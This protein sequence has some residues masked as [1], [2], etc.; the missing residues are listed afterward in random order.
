LG[1]RKPFRTLDKRET[2]DSPSR[3]VDA[4]TQFVE[5][6]RRYTVACLV[7]SSAADV[8]ITD[9]EAPVLFAARRLTCVS[10]GHTR[11][12]HQTSFQYHSPEEA[13]DW[14]F[15]L[16]YYSQKPC[17]GHTLW[18]ANREH[19]EFVRAYVAA[20]HRARMRGASGWTN[21]SAASRMPKWISE[22]KNRSAI[23]KSLDALEARMLAELVR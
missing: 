9:Q 15:G 7:C 18:V 16:P 23:L 5:F 8:A 11:E 2:T 1:V 21:K 6:L 20:K 17:A 19:L 10:C 14:Y 22:A 4:G 3:F 12:W 13:I